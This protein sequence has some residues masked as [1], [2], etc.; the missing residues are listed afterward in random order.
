MKANEAYKRR[1]NERTNASVRKTFVCFAHDSEISLI[2]R[3]RKEHSF[4][5]RQHQNEIQHLPVKIFK[6]FS[7]TKSEIISIYIPKNFCIKSSDEMIIIIICDMKYVRYGRARA[8]TKF[9]V[10]QMNSL[11]DSQNK[12]RCEPD[13][14]ELFL[15]ACVY[16]SFLLF[17]IFN[18]GTGALLW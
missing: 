12:R 7:E 6:R 16:F 10:G 5:F 2:G 13:G 1:A 18:D 17:Y 11:R 3:E 15:V 14:R 9:W 4:I 8:H